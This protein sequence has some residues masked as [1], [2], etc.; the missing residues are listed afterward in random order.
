M[1]SEEGCSG[2]NSMRVTQNLT[3]FFGEDARHDQ[4][5]A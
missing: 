5:K 2:S 3:E 1:A 4:E